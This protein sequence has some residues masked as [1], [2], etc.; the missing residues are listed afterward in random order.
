MSDPQDTFGLQ[1]E[2]A[3]ANAEVRRLN[4]EVT[5]WMA[6]YVEADKERERLRTRLLVSR[7]D[8]AFDRCCEG[9]TTASMCIAFE[10]E[11]DERAER[12]IETWNRRIAKVKAILTA[13]RAELERAG[14]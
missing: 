13:A 4:I 5:S 9:Y 12:R 8:H 3:T 7:A 10:P 11:Y 2:L 6:E 14:R 1:A